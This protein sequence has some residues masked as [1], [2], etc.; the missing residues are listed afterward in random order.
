M[1]AT[2]AGKSS[3]RPMFADLAFQFIKLLT[4]DTSI[5]IGDNLDSETTDV[6]MVHFR[7]R[8]SGRNVTFVDT[9][10]FNDSR[11]SNDNTDILKRNVGF[12][13]RDCVYL[14]ESFVTYSNGNL[15]GMTRSQSGAVS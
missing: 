15:Q 7:D 1:G 3:V 13:L 6:Q 10:G 11:G 5:K 9:P 12:L 2:G 8:D 14:S 4:G